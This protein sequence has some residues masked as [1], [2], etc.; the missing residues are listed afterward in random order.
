MGRNR[1]AERADRAPV[2]SGI[3]VVAALVLVAGGVVA[4]FAM[5][6]GNYR[7]WDLIDLA[8]YRA[9]GEAVLH[10][11]SVY[12]EYVADQ[13]RIPLPFI[14]PPF[15]AVL[16]IPFALLGETP[17]NIVYT[18]IT[19][20]LLAGVV[21]VCFA[22]LLAR[23]AK[24]WFAFALVALV[25]LSVSPVEDHLRFGQVGIPLMAACVFDCMAA[26][27]RWPRGL[28]VG[29]ATAVKL[30][31]GIFIPYFLLT[32]RWRAAAVASATFVACSLI[33]L[34]VA[35][36]DSWTF[37]TDKMF[38]PT[39]PEFVSNQSLEGILERAI[40]PWRLV[41]I[42]AVVFVFG[43]GLWRAARA[44][45]AGD[46]LRGI[47][48]VGVVSLIVS[49]I[50]WIHHMVWIIPALA[51]IVG[52]AD[53]RRRVVV[54]IVVTALFIARLPYVGD[55]TMGGDG[56]LAGIVIDSYGLIAIGLFLLLTDA[57]GLWRRFTR[58]DLHAA[59]A[60]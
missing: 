53:D 46:E 44:S 45:R 29:I 48:I 33:G 11:R 12:G 16:A 10:G 2:P 20:A 34:A 31:P 60:A 6:R 15:A 39:S 37:W 36:S 14:Y 51:V 54:A 25:A 38:E 52:R 32:R 40:G 35:P 23:Y 7:P 43:F 57:F 58:A 19:V 5:Q 8:V 59:T 22:P 18:G 42:P 50:S 26:R 27:P 3:L 4:A 9:A 30:V 55:D 21:K 41:W 28:L 49:P 13:L 1:E 17:A 24:S 56:F 47:A